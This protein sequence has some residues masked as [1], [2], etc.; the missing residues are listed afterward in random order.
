MKFMK[1][2]TLIFIISLIFAS[3]FADDYYV[4]L[5]SFKEE[6]YY[7]AFTEKLKNAGFDTIVVEADSKIGKTNRVLLDEKYPSMDAA[8]ERILALKKD[9]RTRKLGISGIW[10]LKL[11][12]KAVPA[13]TQKS[14]NIKKIQPASPVVQVQKKNGESVKTQA[15]LP[16]IEPEIPVIEQEPPVIVPDAVPLVDASE[17]SKIEKS[18]KAEE[19]VKTEEIKSEGNSVEEKTAE[20]KPAEEPVS[21]EKTAEEKTVKETVPAV[22]PVVVPDAVPAAEENAVS[23]PSVT[24]TPAAAVEENIS[25]NAVEQPKPEEAAKTEDVK[26]EEKPAENTPVAEEK[27]PAAETPSP[28][29]KAPVPVAESAKEVKKSAPSIKFPSMKSSHDEYEEIA[30]LTPDEKNRPFFA[31]R[32]IRSDDVVYELMTYTAKGEVFSKITFQKTKGSKTY[33]M[34]TEIGTQEVKTGKP[35]TVELLYS[36]VLAPYTKVVFDWNKKRSEYTINESFV[37]KYTGDFVKLSS[38]SSAK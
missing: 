34:L 3:V 17:E 15:P 10:P 28:A 37:E 32:K 25:L 1:K 21:V 18:V 35:V 20:E 12:K 38:A 5:G 36:G 7:S 24:E 9:P 30:L 31:V 22:A 29:E 6:K 11:E 2:F 23:S 16:V 26:I 33:E 27:A 19:P 13:V 4:C 14:Q 8:H